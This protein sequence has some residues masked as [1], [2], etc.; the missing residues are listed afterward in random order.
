MSRDIPPFRADHVG[1]L[2][3]PRRLLDAREDLA[4][5][6]ITAAELRTIEDEEI[7]KVVEMQ[8]A[9]GLQDATDG[10]FR[11][12]SWHMD[13][14]YQLGGITQVQDDTIRVAF[15]SKDKDYEYAPPSAHVTAPI[16]LPNTI[17]ADDFRF[18]QSVA[19]AA[20]PKLTIPSPNMVHYRGGP[21]AKS[22]RACRSRRVRSR[23]PT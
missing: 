5:G 4:K 23:L 12:S 9:A 1:S 18:L 16:S 21:A 15:H 2:L 22:S 7:V 8:R 14:I 19:G 20:T 11:R 13:F 17:F 6:S 10:E 3:R